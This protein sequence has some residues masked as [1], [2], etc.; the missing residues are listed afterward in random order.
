[1]YAAAVWDPRERTLRL[2]RDPLGIKPLYYT[3]V[4]SSDYGPVVLFA[5]ELRSLLG[6]GMVDRKLN[7][8]GLATYAWNGFVAEPETIIAGVRLLPAGSV[9]TIR[10]DHPEVRI[11]RF[12]T[13]PTGQPTTDST[14]QLRDELRAAVS[15]R[16]VSDVPLG[17]FLSGGIDSSAVTALAARACST[18]LQTFSIGFE[19]S[20]YDE[21]IFARRVAGAVGTNHHE[22]RLSERRFA[23]Q[24][25]DALRSID[26]PTFDQI[27]TYFVSRAVKE[28]GITVALAGTGGDEVFGGYRS[29]MDLPRAAAWARGC[30]RIPD[31][32]RRRLAA[33]VTRLKMGAS[34][35]VPPQSRWGKLGDALAT[36]GNLGALYQVSYSLFCDDFLRSLAPVWYPGDTRYGLPGDAFDELETT[37]AQQSPLRAISYLELRS[38]VGQRLLRDTDAAS[39]AVSLEVRVPLLDHKLIEAATALNDATRYRAVGSKGLLRELALSRIDPSIFDRAKSGFVLPIDA[40]CRQELRSEVE[41]TLRDGELCR[42]VGLNPSSVAALWET[43]LDEAPGI[44]WSSVWSLFV[45]LWW[46]RENGVSV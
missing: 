44:Y 17:I 43:F 28:A 6:S 39:M 14:D 10:V 12:W 38:F 20:E 27:N 19:E 21:S 45:L 8:A 37:V 15:M 46:S 16:L 22:I 3:T 32:A 29:F 36:G 18:E 11:R 25:S 4:D 31:S 23:G 2:V 13:M 41:E 35:R 30:R 5:S 24:L 34:G 9:A 42:R 40:W 7:P 26:Q 33:V 1:M